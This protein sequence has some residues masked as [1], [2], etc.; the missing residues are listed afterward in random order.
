MARATLAGPIARVR[1]L[2]AA[3]TADYTDDAVEAVLDR[4]RCDFADDRLVPLHET[5]SGGTVR[6][7]V[8][9]SA[10]RNLEATDGGSAVL[11]VRNASG[12]R[13]GTADYSVDEAAGRVTFAADT[14]GSAYY[15]TGRSYDVYAAAAE[16]WRMKAAAVAERFDFSADGA[17]FKAS[18]LID[19]YNRMADQCSGMATFGAGA[20]GLRTSTMV[21]EDLAPDVWR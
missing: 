13:A 9:R 19:Q 10:Y 3:G 21:R 7:Y 20:A 15:L 5:D 8:H 18:Q 16:I 2:A 1:E 4:N 6:Y 12:T 17:S 11:Y 14:A